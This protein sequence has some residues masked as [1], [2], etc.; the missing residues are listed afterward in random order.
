MKKIIFSIFVLALTL[1]A[2]EDEASKGVSS[3]TTYADMTLKGPEV[4]NWEFGTPYVDP[5]IVAMEGTTDISNKV[6]ISEINVNQIGRYIITY[7]VLN[8][9]GF[10]ATTTRTVYVYKS[11]DTRN[12]Y[13]DSKVTRS[14][15]GA[16]Y[17]SR[18]PY[19]HG[20]KVLGN[21]TDELWVED[22][23]GGW[24]YIGSN[25][26]IDYAT[27]GVVKLNTSSEPNSVTG[28]KNVEALPW[29]YVVVPTT[30]EPSSYTAATKTLQ[31]N[32]EVTGLMKFRVTLN[33]P[34]PL[35]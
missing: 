28:L 33:N 10:A 18:G 21:G 6:T 31:V 23:I 4:L 5:G 14:Y 27:A 30:A 8:S 7:K 3:I 24:Y 22:L 35:N 19:A 29:G 17:T 1:S 20:I 11:S 15:N 26:G 13:Y 25:Y 2:C 32:V 9:D 34:T 12:G 16:A